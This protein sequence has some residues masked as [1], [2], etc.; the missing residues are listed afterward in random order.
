VRGVRPRWLATLGPPLAAALV[1]ILPNPGAALPGWT[2]YFRDMTLTYIPM[3][4]F[5]VGEMTRGRWPFWNPYLAEGSPVLPMLYPLEMLQAV[6]PGPA[7]ASWLLTLHLPLAALA[8]YALARELQVSPWGAF[9]TAAVFSL[10]GLCLSSL[11]LH[12]FL[13]ALAWAPLL[14][15]ALRRAAFRG[16]RWMVLAALVLGIA[17]STLAL[18]FVVQALVLGVLLSLAAPRKRIAGLRIVASS[19]LGLGLAALPIALTV[20]ILAESVRGRGLVTALQNSV[21]PAALLQLL[22]PDLLGSVSEPLRFWWGGRLLDGGS[23]YFMSLYVGPAALALALAGV[24]APL[25][26]AGRF[27]WAVGLLG[28]WYALGAR[29]GLAPILAPIVP[30]VRFPVKAFLS[31][32][33]AL[34]LFAGAGFDGLRRGRGW[35]RLGGF[36]LAALLLFGGVALAVVRFSGALAEWLDISAASTDAMR[37]TLIAEAWT[38]GLFSLGLAALWILASRGGRWLRAASTALSL[39]LVADLARGAIGMNVQ[40]PPTFFAP[41]PGLAAELGDLHG[42]RV[43]SYGAEASPALAALLRQRPPG[44]ERTAFRL[45]REL[46]NPFTNLIDRVEVAEGADRLSFVPHPP[47]VRPWEHDPRLLGQILP[48]L[49]NASVS[50][51]LTL[52]PLE[53]PE[54]RLRATVPT[55]VPSLPIRVYDLTAPWPRVYVA[56]RVVPVEGPGEA[57]AAALSPGFDGRRDVA[58]EETGGASCSRGEASSAGGSADRE[59][60]EVASDGPGYLVVRESHTRN[61][62]AGIDG[63]PSVVL[64]AN[65]RHRAVA[66]PGGRHRVELRYEPPGLLAGILAT[67]AALLASTLLLVRPV[68]REGPEEE[69]A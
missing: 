34:A 3:R 9:V 60:F 59:L 8:A 20:G 30:W 5:V 39:L 1:P 25:A 69:P 18:E 40:V 19:I 67:A 43:F 23:P 63:A 15:L 27:L 26:G 33:L 22:L 62:T 44:I 10:G 21:H 54:V 65:G 66:I 14:V 58:L 6:W 56:C 31:T 49:R 38:G 29:G 37:R 55:E 13:Q 17:V 57:L 36:G 68:L 53:H 41:L 51:I 61:W 47:T 48:R 35:R 7:A 24:R 32:H 28:A 42:G 12:W 11:N 50:R 16:G 64:R 4:A 45:S 46:L 52:D 2:Y